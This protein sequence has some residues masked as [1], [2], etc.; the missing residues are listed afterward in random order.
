MA[1]KPSVNTGLGPLR[2]A[3]SQDCDSASSL[4]ADV[5]LRLRSTERIK[6]VLQQRCERCSAPVHLLVRIRETIVSIT[7]TRDR[8][9]RSH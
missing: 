7:A 3:P 5:E 4:P 8:T 6:L 9:P 1:D 2:A